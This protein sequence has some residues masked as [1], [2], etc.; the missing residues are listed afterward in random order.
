MGAH[1]CVAVADVRK[2]TLK[3]Y[4]SLGAPNDNCLKILVKYT[5]DEIVAKKVPVN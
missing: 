5:K 3:Y 2:K 4:G 1:W